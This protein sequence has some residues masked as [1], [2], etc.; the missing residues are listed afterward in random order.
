MKWKM[1]KPI[2][3]FV[4]QQYGKFW[5]VSLEHFIKHKPLISEEFQLCYNMYDLLLKKIT[6][7]NSSN[8]D[9][10]HYQGCSCDKA[11]QL[12]YYLEAPAFKTAS[13]LKKSITTIKV[14]WNKKMWNFHIPKI[15]QILKNFA[16]TFHQA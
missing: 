15:W 11:H 2:W 9:W 5:S 3:V 10:K 6:T 12:L 7:L 1:K 16:R 13:A 14:A 4:F 8:L